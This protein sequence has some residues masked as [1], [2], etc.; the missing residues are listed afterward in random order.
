MMSFLSYEV[1]LD[2]E[3]LSQCPVFLLI[4]FVGGVGEVAVTVRVREKHSP[5]FSLF[6]CVLVVVGRC[7]GVWCLF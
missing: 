4:V 1:I 5:F 7:D 6:Y 2:R 3:A